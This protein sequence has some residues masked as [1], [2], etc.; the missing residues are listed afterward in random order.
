MH[1]GTCEDQAR[2]RIH[3]GQGRFP[4]WTKFPPLTLGSL[5]TTSGPNLAGARLECD[6]RGALQNQKLSQCDPT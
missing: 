3:S 1:I 4:E 5:K 2:T 6:G